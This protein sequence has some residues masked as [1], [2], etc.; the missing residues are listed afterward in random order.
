MIRIFLIRHAQTPWN[1]ERRFQGRTDI[2]L[3]DYGRHQAKL[4]NQVL[5]NY[6]FDAAYSSPSQR[7]LETALISL[8]GHELSVDV[9]EGFQEIDGGGFEGNTREENLKKFSDVYEHYWDNPNATSC[10]PGGETYLEAQRRMVSTLE[11]VVQNRREHQQIVVF[12][13]GLSLKLMLLHYLQEPFSVIRDDRRI[14]NCSLSLL[15][16]EI[17]SPLKLISIGENLIPDI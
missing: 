9:D 6:K 10:G 13:H 4:L 14:P 1:V 5:Q 15:E 2:P 11:S 12:S 3:S 7:A 17:G 8:E 16:G